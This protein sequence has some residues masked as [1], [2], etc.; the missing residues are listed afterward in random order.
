[1]IEDLIDFAKHEPQCHQDMVEQFLL[2]TKDEL[3]AFDLAFIGL[4]GAR[5]EA[6]MLRKMYETKRGIH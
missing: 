1:M 5:I 4:A 3:M 2:C 6:E